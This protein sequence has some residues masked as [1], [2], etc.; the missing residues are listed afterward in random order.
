MPFLMAATYCP[1]SAGEYLQELEDKCAKTQLR[2]AE[3]EKYAHVTYFF[4]GGEETPNAGEDRILVP[5]PKVATY[6]LQPE[7]N[8]P[9]VT[10]KVVERIESGEYDMIMLN[11]CQRRHGRPYGR[12]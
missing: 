11:F 9:I 7:M 4:N 6:D 2:I 10:D 12:V 8:A 1:R 5:S 3:T